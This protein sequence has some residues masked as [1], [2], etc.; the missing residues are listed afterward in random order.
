QCF[1]G[2]SGDDFDRLGESTACTMAC[3]GDDSTTCGGRSAISVYF[4]SDPEEEEYTYLGCFADSVVD[5][6]LS[7]AASGNDAELTIDACA[8]ACDGYAFFGTE[9]GTECF[10]GVT[11]DDPD[12]LGDATC[13][14]DCSGDASETCGGRNAISVYE[15]TNP[16]SGYAG[17]FVD[18]GSDRVLTG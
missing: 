17:C 4:A 2:A 10:C 12:R 15:F 3:S 11:S 9:F 8:E 6:V 16:P 7:I 18:S 13:N 1:C 5:R 14:M